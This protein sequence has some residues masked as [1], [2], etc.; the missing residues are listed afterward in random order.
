MLPF[1]PGQGP[2]P[3]AVLGADLVCAGV[4]PKRTAVCV[5]RGSNVRPPCGLSYA[6][7]M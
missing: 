3:H 6:Q 2:G 5:A 4:K 1:A 7:T